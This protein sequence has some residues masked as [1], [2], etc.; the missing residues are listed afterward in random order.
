LQNR[1]P[2]SFAAPQL[3][4]PRASAV[5]Q[6]PQNFDSARFSVPQLEQIT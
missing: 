1:I 6:P 3:G 4:Q 5:P 2:G